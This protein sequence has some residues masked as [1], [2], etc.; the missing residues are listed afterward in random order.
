MPR[1]TSLGRGHAATRGSS[2]TRTDSERFAFGGV[3]FE[4]LRQ[5]AE[6]GPQVPQVSHDE[7]RFCVRASE[8]GSLPIA[9]VL[10]ALHDDPAFVGAPQRQNWITFERSR[11]AD[12]ATALIARSF[13]AE[14]M[15]VG[16]HRYAATARLGDGVDGLS[17][18]LRGISA[19]V[20]HREG[21]LVL[22]AAALELDGRA[23]LFVG[24]SG[25]G[26]STAVRLTEAGRCFAYDHVALAPTRNGWYAWGLPGGTAA[27]APLAPHTVYP[28]AAVLRVRQAAFGEPQLTRLTAAQTLFAVRESVEWA[29]ETPAGEDSY[30][31]AATQLS[32][33]VAIGAI[34]TVLRRSNSAALRAWLAR[35]APAATSGAHARSADFGT[36]S[37]V[38]MRPRDRKAS[39]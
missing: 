25:A 9:D 3:A 36:A 30:L 26:K 23:I 27:D 10:C 38:S 1:L 28:L 11:A 31:R 17:G 22:H 2:A 39:S 33:S 4:L 35:V 12:N 8:A 13:A 5:R 14:V 18:L 29:D 7:R 24:P 37:A 19:A 32:S 20:L 34:T 6:G 16:P 21:G 15:S